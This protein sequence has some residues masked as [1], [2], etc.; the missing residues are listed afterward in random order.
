MKYHPKHVEQLADLN[1]LYS[2]AS[3]WMIIA[4]LYDARSIERKKITVSLV[5][6]FHQCSAER[7]FDYNT[8]TL[9]EFSQ[10]CEISETRYFK[11]VLCEVRAEAEQGLKCFVFFHAVF[12][13]SVFS[14]G[15]TANAPAQACGDFLTCCGY[16]V[17]RKPERGFGPVDVSRYYGTVS[18]TVRCS[19][20][21]GR[22]LACPPRFR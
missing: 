14:D 20:M 19:Q 10:I 5:M 9:S 16:R 2:V 22:A 11:A 1:K 12:T 7:I 3:C 8:S 4:I 6:S 18:Y 15:E 17:C 13:N 21:R